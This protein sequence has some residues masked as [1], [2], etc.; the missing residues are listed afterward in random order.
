M[1]VGDEGCATLVDSSLYCSHGNVF[2]YGFLGLSPSFSKEQKTKPYVLWLS[3]FQNGERKSPAT[4]AD[5][6]ARLFLSAN[7]E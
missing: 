7:C 3:Q 5:F 4:D 2:V 1:E 6:R